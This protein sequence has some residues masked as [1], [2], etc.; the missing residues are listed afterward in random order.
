[1]RGL[2]LRHGRSPFCRCRLRRR[3]GAGTI[4]AVVAVTPMETMKTKMIEANLGL[5]AG[6]R[7]ILAQVRCWSRVVALPPLCV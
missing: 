6:V 1:M 7:A 4:E 2:L 5:V 3:Q